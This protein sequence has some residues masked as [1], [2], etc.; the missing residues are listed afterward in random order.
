[1]NRCI[2]PVLCEVTL[3]KP[4]K[5]RIKKGVSNIALENDELLLVGQFRHTTAHSSQRE[6]VSL[7]PS[8]DRLPYA[9][10]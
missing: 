4:S 2:G 8:T 9:I 1:M 5:G 10:T 6:S 7:E 3:S